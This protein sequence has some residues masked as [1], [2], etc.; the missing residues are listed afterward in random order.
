MFTSLRHIFGSKASDPPT[1]AVPPGMR[2]YVVGDIHG[3]LDLFEALI[4]A[5]EAD[6]RERPEARTVM[7]LLGDLVDRGPD[8]AGVVA[9]A[10][11]WAD[12]RRVILLAGNHEE[13]FLESF[14]DPVMLRHFLRHGGRQ[15]ILS[16]GV[17]VERYDAATFDELRELMGA[18]V[19]ADD[20]RFLAQ[21]RDFHVAG[22]YLMVHAG[23][24]PDVA[25][26]DQQSHHLRWIRE[27]FLEHDLPHE[28][29]VIHGHTITDAVDE[30]SNRIGIDTG[31][32]RSGRLTA[33][34]LEG[35]ERRIIQAVERDGTIDIET[36]AQAE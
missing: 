20:I 10:R 32:Y 15:T 1:P 33:L 25:L 35:T 2:Y 12:E 34:A 19:P 11:R 13:M 17:P 14:D 31:A 30:Q 16:Y 21:G 24:V 22:D 7:V 23:I 4:G 5:V 26:E 29:F 9:R 6:D 18:A 28:R 8:S 3:R 36:E 27:P